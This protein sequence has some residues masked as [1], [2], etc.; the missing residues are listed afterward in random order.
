MMASHRDFAP[1]AAFVLAAC[2]VL[3]PAVA[4]PSEPAP[5]GR[6]DA[7]DENRDRWDK[8]APEA[9][10]RLREAYRKLESLPPEEL[11]ILLDRLRAM[12]PQARREAIDAARR[13]LRRA[14]QAEAP[15]PNRPPR[16]TLPARVPGKETRRSRPVSGSG[17]G[18][19]Q[20]NGPPLGPLVQDLP[21]QAR[22]RL[23]A[24]PPE[25]R[26]REARRMADR[27]LKGWVEKLPAPLRERVR[28]FTKKEQID[29]FRASRESDVLGRTFSRP[30]EEE[31]LLGLASD[32]ARALAR[33]DARKPAEIS[34]ESWTR[35]QAIPPPMRHRLLRRLDRIRQERTTEGQDAATKGQHLEGR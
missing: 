10:Q 15:S 13:R 27:M 3:A 2:V 30:G 35:W 34:D 22:R 12:D 24:L 33:P 26:A 19:S 21:P 6:P 32:A 31:A 1:L 28:R 14:A 5:P 18:A 20:G 8:L 29:L 17:S 4:F 7:R 16:D 25:E 9:R 11:R 23:E